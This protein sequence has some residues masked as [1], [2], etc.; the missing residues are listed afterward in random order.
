MRYL[1]TA[2]LA[3][4]GLETARAACGDDVLVPFPNGG[5][6]DDM[7]MEW[8]DATGATFNGID[9][10]ARVHGK[11]VPNMVQP[12]AT[13]TTGAPFPG[14]HV[15]FTSAGT[16]E[17]ELFDIVVTVVENANFYSQL[18]FLPLEYVTPTTETATQAYWEQTTGYMC[19]GFGV[20]QSLCPSGAVPDFSTAV[21][22]E[23]NQGPQP[24]IMRATEFDIEF[25]KAGT[26]DLI[27]APDVIQ[28]TFLGAHSPWHSLHIPPA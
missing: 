20:H 18:E 13:D 8:T 17:G 19:L 4:G 21:C 10:A 14:G 24:T 23:T 26:F 9:D 22:P 3:L 16:H 28:L 25:V 2:M 1:S 6:S 5:W 15:R 7:A 11:V 12:M 27:D